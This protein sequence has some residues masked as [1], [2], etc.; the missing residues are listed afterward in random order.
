M[1]R[2]DVYKPSGPGPFP[3][4]LDIHGGGWWNG[5]KALG[6]RQ[7][8]TFTDAGI[9][10]VGVN[11]RLLRD[12]ARQKVDP[13]VTACLDDVRY[14][15]QFVRHYATEWGLDGRRVALSGVSAGGFSALW[16]GLSD[17]MAKPDSPDPIA[18]ESTRVLAIGV[19]DAQTSIDPRQMRRWVGPEL[20]YGGH[21]FGLP[22]RNFSKFLDQRSRYEPFFPKLSPAA[23]VSS[24]DPPIFLYYKLAPDEAEKDH[25]FFVHSPKFGVELKKLAEPLGLECHVSYPGLEAPRFTDRYDFIVKTLTA[26]ST[27]SGCF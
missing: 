17:E 26:Q 19:R 6:R 5:D 13:P 25:S 16:L 24:D 27:D 2:L 10:I 18:R 7:V 8:E 11:Y 20:R 21:A 15:L 9:A 22:E 4:V 14:A 12:A 3:F 23:L 1:Q